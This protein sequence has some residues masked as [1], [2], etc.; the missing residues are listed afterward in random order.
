M[1]CFIF[2]FVVIVV[3]IYHREKTYLKFAPVLG[4]LRG[5]IWGNSKVSRAVLQ[6]MTGH[7]NLGGYLHRIGKRDTPEC[8]FCGEEDETVG[9]FLMR[10]RRWDRERN[11][12]SDL[13]VQ[14]DE[15]ASFQALVREVERLA[16]F[17]KRTSRLEYNRT[18]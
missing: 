1:L 6:L 4:E 16:R 18:R 7:C 13:L 17:V 9:H 10:C 14:G 15:C 12:I 2:E 11:E 5:H 8:S 3:M